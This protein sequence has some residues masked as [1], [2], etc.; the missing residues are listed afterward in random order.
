MTGVGGDDA[1]VMG[2]DGEPMPVD[3][4]TLP[5]ERLEA[6]MIEAGTAGDDAMVSTIETILAR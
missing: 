4:R 2:P 5:V 6:L 1:T 3:L